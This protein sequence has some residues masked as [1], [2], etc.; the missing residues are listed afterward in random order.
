MRPKAVWLFELLD[1]TNAYG[2]K[3]ECSRQDGKYY[4]ADVEIFPARREYPS[5]MRYHWR[6]IHNDPLAGV[7]SVGNGTPGNESKNQH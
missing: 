3:E 6:A 2:G 1:A 5:A 4:I 7:W